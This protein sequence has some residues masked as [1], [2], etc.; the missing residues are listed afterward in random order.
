M[1]WKVIATAFV[2]IFLAEIGDK[3]QLAA[4]ALSGSGSSKWAVFIGASLALVAATAVAVLAGS[5]V[6]RHVPAHWVKRAAGGLFIVIGVLLLV[7]QRPTASEP[8][9]TPDTGA[10]SET[11]ANSASSE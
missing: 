7:T 10:V 4:F 5:F 8:N 9:A 6:E 11:N 3:T 2:S 1:D